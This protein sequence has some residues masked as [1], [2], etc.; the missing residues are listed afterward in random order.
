MELSISN[1]FFLNIYKSIK[2]SGRKIWNV[3]MTVKNTSSRKTIRFW[4]PI[5]IWQA[6]RGI[7]QY[8]LKTENIFN[9]FV[10]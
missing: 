8:L 3:S 5:I 4:R 1:N 7:M 9:S 10:K 6:L 2:E